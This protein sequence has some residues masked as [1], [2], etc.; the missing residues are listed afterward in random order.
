MLIYVHLSLYSYWTNRWSGIRLSEY[1]LKSQNTW[2]N[3]VWT[4]NLCRFNGC[5]MQCVRI[6]RNHHREVWY[7]ES[8]GVWT[9]SVCVHIE[10][11]WSIVRIRTTPCARHGAKFSI[12]RWN[13][14]SLG[15]SPRTTLYEHVL[16]KFWLGDENIH[17]CRCERLCYAN[18]RL[19]LFASTE[20]LSATANQYLEW[21][22][23]RLKNSLWRSIQRRLS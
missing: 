7:P 15:L 4:D 16:C 6:F 11:C 9:F 10:R 22:K 2:N 8:R 5:A 21:R 13:A 23:F 20:D 3:V 12:M 14:A 17:W 19:A 1:A 18:R